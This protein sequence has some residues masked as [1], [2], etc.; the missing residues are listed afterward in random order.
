[1]HCLILGSA[2]PEAGEWHHA[3]HQYL[4]PVRALS[5]RFRGRMVGSLRSSVRTSELHRVIYP[6]AIDDVL[7]EVMQKDWVVYARHCLNQAEDSGGL[8]GPLHPSH[9]HQQRSFGVTGR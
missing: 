3:K 8:P 9:C 7:N 1:M 4:F 5:R 2:L 6:G